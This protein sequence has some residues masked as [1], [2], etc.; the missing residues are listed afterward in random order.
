MKNTTLPQELPPSMWQGG[1]LT[2]PGAY[3]HVQ[4]ARSDMAQP[5]VR[6]HPLYRHL[7]A[8]TL[9]LAKGCRH[10]EGAVSP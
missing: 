2:M 7:R 3:P 8:L 6:L 4:Q 1:L 9:L 5:V 10:L